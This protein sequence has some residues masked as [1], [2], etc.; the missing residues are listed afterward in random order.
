MRDGIGNYR[1]FSQ[2][3]ADKLYLPR[4]FTMMHIP[5]HRCF[6]EALLRVFAIIC[7]IAPLAAAEKT[8][9]PAAAGFS[10]GPVGIGGRTQLF[11]DQML[12]RSSLG[13]S[14]RLHPGAKHPANP[15]IR[16][17]QPWEGWRLGL[18][19]NVIHDLE[20]KK[21]RMWYTSD[22]SADFPN[23]AVCYAESDDGIQ[24]RKPLIGTIDSATGNRRHNA[25]LNE[26]H[27]PSVIKDASDP[28]PRRRY[29]MIAYIHKDKPAGGPHSF[30]SPDGLNWTRVSKEPICRSNDVITAYYDEQRQLY[31]AFPKHSTAVRGQVRRCFAMS[32]S[33]DFSVWS[34]PR[35]V[36]TPDLRDDAGSLAR[37]EEVRSQLDVPDDPALMRT[38]FYGIGVY[39]AESCTLAFPW[40]FTIN[41]NARYGNHEGPSEI[42]LAST[43]DLETWERPFRT[44]IVPHGRPGEWDCGFLASQ[45]RAF[46]VGDEIRLYYAGANYT[47]G[48][49]CLYREEG[50]GR[51]TRFTDSIGLATWKLDRFVSVDG[52]AES[53]SLVTVPVVFTGRRLELNA[54]ATKPEAQITVEFLDAAGNPDKAWGI[55][56]P[57]TGDSLRQCVT[58]KGMT[59]VASFAGK[60]VSLRFTLRSASL[61]SF[62]FRAD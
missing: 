23:F 39:P 52:P 58:W 57:V 31:V 47:H 30:V 32:T 14:F 42:Q 35:Y 37:I 18:Y 5:T 24:W 22:T 54:V 46:R 10:G 33:K 36:F 45:S 34:A 55:S 40:V 28:D 59:D 11:V 4:T 43:R 2:S 20:L 8:V 61:F 21:F 19:G 26:A 9:V 50:T 38:E 62:A 44:P 13:V 12:V 51:G 48:T 56:D 16:A 49:P 3:K 15:L 60:P 1:C 41:N 27:L 6:L 7:L 29:K 25:V 17:D 53:G